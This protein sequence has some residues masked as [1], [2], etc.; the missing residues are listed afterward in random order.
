[1]FALAALKTYIKGRWG[2]NKY[3]CVAFLWSVKV[4]QPSQ[5][6]LCC[7]SLNG[8][9]ENNL[10][11]RICFFHLSNHLKQIKI[12]FWNLPD[13]TYSLLISYIFVWECD[14]FT[15]FPV[16]Y[17]NFWHPLVPSCLAFSF[18]LTLSLNS[19]NNLI[20]LLSSPSSSHESKCPP[21]IS[22]SCQ[23]AATALKHSSSP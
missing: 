15:F 1:M 7:I 20:P 14:S 10:S 12:S 3:V 18:S 13:L 2:E 11:L 4:A 19:L 17:P 6:Q 23:E 21:S 16:L 8:P 9:Y 22:L 5:Q